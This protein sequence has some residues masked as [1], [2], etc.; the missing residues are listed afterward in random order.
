MPNAPRS[1]KPERDRDGVAPVLKK[2]G[3]AL[4]VGLVA[5][6][7]L[8]LTLLT[9][10]GFWFRSGLRAEG[11]VAQGGEV[12]VDAL[13]S[14]LASAEERLTAAAGLFRASDTVTQREFALFAADVGVV[15][16]MGGLGFIALVA[17]EDL[18]Q[19][20]Q[21]VSREIPGYWVFERDSEGGR[22]PVG[23]RSVYYPTRWFEPAAAFDRPHGFRLGLRPRCAAP[24][25]RRPPGQIPLSHHRFCSCSLKM[26]T[27]G[28]FSIDEWPI[29][30]PESSRGSPW[31]QWI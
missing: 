29:P 13:S 30:G 27:T 23:S 16:G 24:P 17:S 11:A 9:A 28:S 14:G 18:D 4:T 15:E 8:L 22:V 5:I 25:S 31:H 1:G 3:P 2:F 26:T 19:Y 7:V 20:V 6:V 21:D 10:V 12:V